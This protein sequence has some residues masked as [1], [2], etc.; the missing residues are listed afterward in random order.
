MRL[1]Y[2]Y[3]CVLNFHLLK[4]ITITLWRSMNVWFMRETYPFRIF[5]CHREVFHIIFQYEYGRSTMYN[6][7]PNLETYQLS[8][9]F[10]NRSVWKGWAVCGLRFRIL[11]TGSRND[12][13]LMFRGSKC[14]STIIRK[15]IQTPSKTEGF[16]PARRP[17][18][19]PVGFW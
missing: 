19:V 17:E 4:C 3:I 2:E 18:K 7:D 9:D 1:F 13:L 8:Q 10:A 5:K 12:C 15:W 6:F 11:N 14:I 16:S